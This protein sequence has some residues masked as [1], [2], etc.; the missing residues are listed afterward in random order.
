MVTT[1]HTA[2]FLLK[3]HTMTLGGFEFIQI[4][5]RT[6]KHTHTHLR[7]F[8]VNFSSSSWARRSSVSR[9]C[10]VESNSVSTIS[11]LWVV[12]DR[13]LRRSS[14]WSWKELNMQ[15]RE[16]RQ[17]DSRRPSKHWCNLIA[18]KVSHIYKA[19]QRKEVKTENE[20]QQ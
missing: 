6:H 10:R 15:Q 5:K 18:F 11:S 19:R 3:H 8:S 17:Q 7:S 13:R 9:Y 14:L 1:Q 16:F 2:P 12:Y 20:K 4:L